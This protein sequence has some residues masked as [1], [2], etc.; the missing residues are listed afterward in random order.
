[1]K[2]W[3]VSDIEEGKQYRLHLCQSA[4][5]KRYFRLVDAQ[6]SLNSEEKFAETMPVDSGSLIQR[7]L[8]EISKNC[9][10]INHERFYVDP[11]GM[12]I[13]QNEADQLSKGVDFFDVKWDTN[14]APN[15]ARR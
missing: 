1:M 9:T 4:E 8:M 7:N 15:V 2:I 14:T 3:S 6:S 13:T 5:G 12:W 11:H 10:L